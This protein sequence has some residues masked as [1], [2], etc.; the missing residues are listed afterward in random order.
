MEYLKRIINIKT[1]INTFILISLILFLLSLYVIFSNRYY[2]FYCKY[3]IVYKPNSAEFI[4]ENSNL[5]NHLKNTVCSNIHRNFNKNI[6]TYY[7]LNMLYYYFEIFDWNLTSNIVLLSKNIHNTLSPRKVLM[8]KVSHFLFQI[9]LTYYTFYI[10]LM[11]ISYYVEKL[12]DLILTLLFFAIISY[13]GTVIFLSYDISKEGYFMVI[14]NSIKE[15][16]VFI[17]KLF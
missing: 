16:I 4:S 11:Y 3:N 15:V 1:K 13:Y 7:S 12:L 9:I 5:H 14:I 17:I 2:F 10:I 6:L 8:I